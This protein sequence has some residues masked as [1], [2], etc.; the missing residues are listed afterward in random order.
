MGRVASR[1]SPFWRLDAK[2]GEVS[3]R[4]L[5]DLHGLGTSICVYHSYIACVPSLVELFGL[6][7]CRSKLCAMWCETLLWFSDFY[8][9]RSRILHYV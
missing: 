2:G 6:F 4:I 9:L 7:V 8:L 3:I 5:G 1:L